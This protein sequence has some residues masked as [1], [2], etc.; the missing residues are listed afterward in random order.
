L[1][2]L[3]RQNG[4]SIFVSGLLFTKASERFFGVLP[5]VQSFEPAVAVES[6]DLLL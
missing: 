4:K 2:S 1:I 3:G 5:D 6:L